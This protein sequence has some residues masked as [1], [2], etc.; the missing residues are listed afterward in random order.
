MRHGVAIAAREA[1]LAAMHEQMDELRALARKHAA[2]DWQPAYPRLGI[3]V[4]ETRTGPLPGLYQPM[5]CFV[6]QGSK[7]VTIGE[8][9]FEYQG[10]AYMIATVD[11]PATGQIVQA[12]P[13]QPYIAVAMALDPATIAALLLELETMPEDAS[14]PGFA[15]NPLTADLV[16]PLLRMVRLLDTPADIGVIA[17]MIEREI[18]YRLLRGPQG[19]MLRQIARSDSRLSQIRRATDWIRRHYAEPLRIERLA[20]LAGMI[21]SSFHRHFKAVTAMTPLQYHKQIRLQEARRRL[22]AEPCE[23]ARVAFSVGYESASQF[24]REYVRLFGLPPA[25]DAARLRGGRALEDA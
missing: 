21:N 13:E 1:N 9:T 20:A 2:T 14:G 6:L 7:R 16:D 5:V 10:A 4:G 8:A 17:P 18:I 23:A 24:S 22:L 3:R 12:S 19:A 15:I 11:L 25:R